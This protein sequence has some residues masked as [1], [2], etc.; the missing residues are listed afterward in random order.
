MTSTVN[1]PTSTSP[2]LWLPTSSL[3]LP[4]NQPPTLS[5][6]TPPHLIF[7]LNSLQ[8]CLSTTTKFVLAHASAPTGGSFHFDAD[9]DWKPDVTNSSEPDTVDLE[10]VAVHEIGHLLG[11]AHSTVN[12]AI[13][14]PYISARTRKVELTKD[15]ID[16]IQ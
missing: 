11:L 12:T 2:L 1:A 3:P 6:L 13:M 14:Y 4:E 5:F 10:S 8:A 15:D 16:G 7:I 9:E